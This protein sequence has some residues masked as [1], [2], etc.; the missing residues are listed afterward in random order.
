MEMFLSIGRD[1]RVDTFSAELGK[2]GRARPFC[3]CSMCA[4]PP[5]TS[6]GDRSGRSSPVKA[7]PLTLER[8]AARFHMASPSEAS[9]A[10]SENAA[11]A[12]G[13]AAS[14]DAPTQS[15]RRL[16]LAG[17]LG[18]AV[19]SSHSSESKLPWSKSSGMP[20]LNDIRARL[21]QRGIDVT[22]SK[23]SP[24]TSPTKLPQAEEAP[25]LVS[26]KPHSVHSETDMTPSEQRHTVRGTEGTQQRPCAKHNDSMQETGQEPVTKYDANEATVHTGTSGVS[27]DAPSG[28]SYQFPAPSDKPKQDHSAPESTHAIRGTPTVVPGCYTGAN[29]GRAAGLA[30]RNG[31]KHPLETQWTLYYDLQ[32]HH[33]PASSDQYEATLKS[34]GHFTSLESFFDTFATLHRPSRLEKNANYHLFKH[35]IKPMWEDPANSEGGR[36]VLTLRDRSQS[37]GGRAAHEALVDRS[38]M[39]LVLALI[40]EQIDE[41]ELINGAVCSLRAKGDRIALWI[42]RKEPIEVVNALGKQLLQILSLQDE[43]NAQL[44]FSPNSGGKDSRYFS[45]PA[46]LKP[47]GGN[48]TTTATDAP[49]EQQQQAETPALHEWLDSELTLHPT[50][51]VRYAAQIHSEQKAKR[52]Q[53]A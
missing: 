12:S 44:E 36:W 50:D 24:K 29:A 40:G 53:Q 3:F 1:P 25:V 41:A 19:E 6:A 17:R 32:R 52:A 27:A 14:T 46:G 43:P 49:V 51:H 33:G 45:K 2:S 48:D 22:P 5:A 20:S 31:T 37:A 11:S 39:W 7:N 4:E 35:G 16:G 38:W 10:V 30:A 9:S 28:T 13:G 23:W 42:R 21:N 8:I 15:L 26:Q 34:I 18:S 47:R